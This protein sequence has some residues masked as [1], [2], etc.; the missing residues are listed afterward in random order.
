MTVLERW[1]MAAL[2]AATVAA[3]G[4]GG[5]A[6]GSDGERQARRD[7]VAQ[8][9]PA[10]KKQLEEK[11]QQFIRLKPEKQDQLRQLHRDLQAQENR[12]ELERVMRAYFEW[13]RTLSA[14]ER[15]HLD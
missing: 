14:S 3:A 5:S 1:A 11:W 7:Y 2:A 9:E 13:V 8:M 4:A 12:E 10:A 15:S 6:G